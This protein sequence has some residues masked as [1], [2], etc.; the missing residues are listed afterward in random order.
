MTRRMNAQLCRRS[1]TLRGFMLTV[2]ASTPFASTI[3]LRTSAAEGE[4]KL[5]VKAQCAQVCVCVLSPRVPVESIS[6]RCLQSMAAA[7]RRPR[8]WLWKSAAR[9]DITPRANSASAFA[10]LSEMS[11]CLGAHVRKKDIKQQ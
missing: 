5:R 6:S 11:A 4:G 3:A 9:G 8:A 1:S 7:E 10:T 2:S